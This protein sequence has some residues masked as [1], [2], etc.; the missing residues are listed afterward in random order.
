MRRSAVRIRSLAPEK[1]QV[2]GIKPGG[3]F[4]FS[5][6]SFQ[7]HASPR[8]TPAMLP[9]LF[10]CFRTSGCETRSLSPPSQSRGLLTTTAKT[11]PSAHIA[12]R[13]PEAMP[14]DAEARAPPL[15]N[16][17]RRLAVNDLLVLAW[18]T[19]GRA[20][21]SEGRTRRENR[22]PA[23]VESIAQRHHAAFQVPNTVARGTAT[24]TT[25]TRTFS[26]AGRGTSGRVP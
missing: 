21:C 26:S 23:S 5:E 12:P 18:S 22:I 4:L 13:T 2:I 17:D 1:V 16:T 7:T 3:L 14:Q 9:S 15:T 24:P 10:Y 20:F 11:N 19:R 25:R 6:L 8:I